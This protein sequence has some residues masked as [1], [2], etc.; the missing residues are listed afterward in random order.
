MFRIAALAALAMVASAMRGHKGHGHGK[1]KG[2]HI[3][4][5]GYA[6]HYGR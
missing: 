5:K 4:K 3:A 1:G 6:A 2:S